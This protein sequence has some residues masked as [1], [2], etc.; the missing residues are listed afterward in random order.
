[1]SFALI[2]VQQFSKKKSTNNIPAPGV[3]DIITRVYLYNAGYSAPKY[4]T[5]VFLC[6]II[7]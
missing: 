1:M 5:L 7:V 2:S 4:S 6:L 3:M